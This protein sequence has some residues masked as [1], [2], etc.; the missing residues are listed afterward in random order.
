VLRKSIPLLAATGVLT[1]A[2]SAYASCPVTV[3]NGETP[4][5]IPAGS[6]SAHG[7]DRMWVYMNTDDGRL[8]ADP[9]GWPW[10]PKLYPDGSVASKF[11]WHARPLRRRARFTI[12]ARRLDGEAK[13][14]HKRSR[15]LR[16]RRGVQALPSS[17]RFSTAGCWKVVGRLGA[18]TRLAWVVSVEL[19][20]S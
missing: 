1:A 20:P 13:P 8:V 2:S 12:T 10:G 17:V 6:S 16:L 5:G 3:P 19:P 14:F 7:N 4:P 18:G 11:L 15:R 9:R